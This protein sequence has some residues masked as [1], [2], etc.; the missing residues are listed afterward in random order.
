MTIK[1]TKKQIFLKALIYALILFIGFFF[2]RNC[3][4]VT[5]ASTESLAST[6]WAARKDNTRL[7]FSNDSNGVYYT[8]DEARSFSYEQIDNMVYFTLIDNEELTLELARIG[9]D[10]LYWPKHN[11]MFYIVVVE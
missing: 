1:L 3:S 8:T 2:V 7:E 6:I 4:L 5:K 9:K 10:K 11:M